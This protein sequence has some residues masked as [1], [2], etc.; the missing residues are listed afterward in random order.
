M[1]ELYV[2]LNKE[3]SLNGMSRHLFYL[4]K[5]EKKVRLLLA[6]AESYAIVFSAKYISKSVFISCI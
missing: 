4:S 2:S 5:D 3:S 1:K 6:C